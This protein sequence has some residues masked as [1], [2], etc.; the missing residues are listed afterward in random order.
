MT[1]QF[2]DGTTRQVLAV[3]VLALVVGGVVGAV[4]VG[5]LTGATDPSPAGTDATDPDVGDGEPGTTI[6][7]GS[8]NGT[9]TARDAAVEQFGSEAS[10]RRYVRRGSAGSAWGGAADGR[11]AAAGGADAG[12][13]GNGN[14]GAATGG[15]G[16]TRRATEDVA[17]QRQGA[18][19]GRVSSTNVQEA[20][21]DEP[22]RLKATGAYLYYARGNEPTRGGPGVG[23]APPEERRSEVD[24]PPERIGRTH[25]FDTRDPAAPERV[26]TINDSGRLLRHGDSLVVIRGDR[27]AG[28]DVSQPGDPTRTWSRTLNGTVASARLHDGTIFLV[29]RTDAG[30]ETPCPARP[31]GGDGAAIPCSDIYHPRGQVAVDA[32]YTAYAL[33]PADGTVR[34]SVAFVGTARE[35][36]L[37]V[38]ANALYVTY[39]ERTDR[40]AVLLETLASPAVDAPEHVL[41][42]LREVR[43]YD[44]SVRAERV[45]A[46]TVVRG[47]LQNLPEEERRQVEQNLSDG[48]QRYVREHRRNLTT[49]GIV[50]VG[51]GNGLAVEAVG[52]VPGV[53]LDQFSMDEHEGRLRITTTVP[54]QYGTDSENDLYVL[55]ATSLER[56]G[57]IQGMGLDQRVYATR[58]VGDTAYVVT[59]RR[60]DPFHV[61]DLSDPAAPKEVGTLK[62]PGFSSYLHP[63]NDTRVLGIGREDGRVKTVLFDVSDPSDPTIADTYFPGA[64]WSAVSESHHGFLLDRRHGVF[65]LPA[66]D[67]GYVVDYTDGLSETTRVDTGGAATR[68]AYVEDYLYVF[69]DRELVVVDERN[70]SVVDRTGLGPV[71]EEPAGVY[72]P[73]LDELSAGDTE[74]ARD[75]VHPDSSLSDRPLLGAGARSS[76]DFELEL[77]SARIRDRSEAT[78]ELVT[79]TVTVTDDESNPY[80]VVV[81]LRRHDGGWRLWSVES[82]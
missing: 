8:G 13:D 70:W 26:G 73:F 20:G 36:A 43:S 15:D 9:A 30:P 78:L 58:Y 74:A 37:Y 60:V 61:V 28:Y 76:E 17:V 6:D 82:R 69:S 63:I 47:W 40:T 3:A 66:S 56:V 25:V 65:F 68:A 45:E 14:G 34:D 33:A 22:D 27:L 75:F 12:G 52:S 44:L 54:R 48:F 5:T 38:S 32:T 10:F 46:Q 18:A 72:Q 16:A 80:R 77:R 59:F 53:P 39:T 50:R 64:S 81:T 24:V 67:G 57:A 4:A 51:L 49:T 29:T 42:R 35:S 31:L 21:I 7:P 71:F 55:N 19:D 23:V 79:T 62:L 2:G 1:R 11:E 41:D